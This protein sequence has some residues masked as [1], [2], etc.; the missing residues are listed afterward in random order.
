M[1]MPSRARFTLFGQLFLAILLVT[2]TAAEATSVKLINDFRLVDQA[3]IVVVARVAGTIPAPELD[4]PVTDYLM[5]VERVLKGTVGEGTI[6]VRVLGGRAANGMELKIWGAPTFG[7]GERALL[8]LGHH[9]DGTYR[10]LHVMLGAFREARMA[11]QSIA[12]RDL[13]EVDVLDGAEAQAT[14]T[15]KVRDFDR[16][17]DWIADRAAAR[18][19]A[20]N[21]YLFLPAD[22]QNSLLPM[23]TLLGDSGRN[24]RW[25]EFDSGGQIQWRID[26]DPLAG[27]SGNPSDAFRTALSAWNAESH[28]P[29]KYTL[30]GTSGLTAGF[31]HFDGQNVLLFDDPNNDVEGDFSCSTGGTLA[32]GGPW[33][34]PDTTGRWNNE[35]FIRIQGADIVVNDGTACFFQRSSNAAKT[36]EELFAHETGH[37]L[38]IGHPSE[39]PN[40][41]N[42]TLRDALMYYRLHNDG[43]GARLASDDIAALRRLYDKTATTGGVGGTGCGVD[44]LC[45]LNNRFEVTLTWSNQFDGSTGVGKPVPFS[46][47]AGFIYF[48]NDPRSLEIAVKIVDFD[49]RILVFYSELT[50]VH[51]RMQV[52]DTATGQTKEYTNTARDCGGIDTNFVENPGTAGLISGGSPTLIRDLGLTQP[53]RRACVPGPGTVCLLGGR[54][55]VTLPA[56]RNQYDGSTGVGS[57]VKMND[58][59]AG[60]HFSSDPRNLELIFKVNQYP[61]RILVFYASLANLEYTIRLTDTITGRTTEFFNPEGNYC[62]G[63]VNNLLAGPPF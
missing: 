44:K 45:L 8:F 15:R 29:I 40:E 6:L 50:V 46:N 58:F 53:P 23:F 34:D 62:G 16:F 12:Y 38:G 28:T 4:R 39:N 48:A 14:E 9:A 57:G 41:T 63:F 51:F 42:P 25:F 43:R 61:D 3:P 10:I 49:G 5:T 54:F 33:F 47:F 52:R 26:G 60:F 32:V 20:P 24:S 30:A 17:A 35:T 59:A 13:S 18:L 56:W 36:V 7:E 1:N 2:V 37:T 21:Y 27:F 31:D 11:G 19:E 22:S 55:A